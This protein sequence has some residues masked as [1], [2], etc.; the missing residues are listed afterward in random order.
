MGGGLQVL[1][2]LMLILRFCSLRL[3]EVLHET[4]FMPIL[5]MVVEGYLVLGLYK[6]TTSEVWWVLGGWIK[7][8]ECTNK[9]VVQSAERGR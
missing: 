7:S 1:L 4:L 8:H 6:W 2:G 3:L 9:G 5:C